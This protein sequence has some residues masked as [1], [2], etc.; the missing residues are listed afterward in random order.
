MLGYFGELGDD[1]YAETYQGNFSKVKDF[2][3]TTTSIVK[4]PQGL[5]QKVEADRIKALTEELKAK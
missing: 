1:V 3:S 4:K 2:F 5:V